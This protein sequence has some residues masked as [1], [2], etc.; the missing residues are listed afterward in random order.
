[1]LKRT[2]HGALHLVGALGAG[3]ALLMLALAWRLSSGPIS[4]TPLTPYAEN[5]LN[6]FH[7]ELRFR[8]GDTV[9]AW[10]GWD[11]TLDMRIQSVRIFEKSGGVIANVPEVS[12]SLSAQALLHGMIAPR[13]IELF[14]PR[15]FL[16]RQADGGFVI[17]LGDIP[18]E[19]QNLLQRLLD[20]LLA[21]TER[22]HPMS[23]LA[24]LNILGADLTIADMARNRSWRLPATQ[25]LI[26]RDAEGL[27]GEATL[28]F[29]TGGG[30]GQVTV[31]SAYRAADGRS[32]ATLTF[33]RARPAAFAEFVEALAPFS[34]LDLPLAGTASIALERNGTVRSFGFNL[35]G[36]EGRLALPDP[37]AQNL[38]LR[39]LA[40]KGHY[41]GIADRLEVERFRLDLGAEGSLIVPGGHAMPLRSAEGRG[42]YARREGRAELTEARFDLGG[43]RVSLAGSGE[44][45][46]ADI[47]V[48]AKGR[49]ENVPADKL[50]LYWPSGWGGDARNWVVPNLSAG[51]MPRAEASLEV[52]IGPDRRPVIVAIDGD[53]DLRDVTVDYLAPMPKAHKVSGRATFNKTRFDI[54]IE[55][56]EAADLAVTGGSIA[57]TGL[58]QYDQYADIELAIAGGFRQ[59]LALIEHEPLRFASALGISPQGAEG[60]VETNLKL[61]FI[62]EHALN[63]NQVDVTANA[64][65]VDIGLRGALLGQDLRQGKLELTLDRKGMDIKGKARVGGMTADIDWRRN[66]DPKATVAS[67]YRLTG[68]S[69]EIRSFADLGFAFGPLG[70]GAVEGTA[71]ADIRVVEG[72]DGTRS[73]EAR[74]D[75]KDLAVE[76]R[77][78]GWRK[79][80]GQPGTAEASLRVKRDTV[81]AIPSFAVAADD[82]TIKGRAVYA[83]DGTGLDR[84]EVD[85]VRYG[86]T[87]ASLVVRQRTD[88]GWDMDVKGASFDFGPLW[89]EVLRGRAA[90]PENETV[91]AL[92]LGITFALDRVW[93]GGDRSLEDVKGAF[94]HDGVRWS[95]AE[96]EGRVGA[97]SAPFI[98]AV[99][100]AADGGKRTLALKAGDAG[101]MLKALDFYDNMVGGTLDIAGEY[102]DRNPGEPLVGRV[103]ARDY[104][105]VNAPLLARLLS[106][107]ALTG[108]LDELKGEGLN[109]AALDLPFVQTEG[110]MELREARA[111]GASLG[112][113]A[114]GKIYTDTDIFDMNGTI[115]PAYAVN[116]LLGNLPVVGT[117]FTGGEK[118][119]GVFAATFRM[120]GPREEP[121]I[122]INPVA[123]LAP[124]FLRNLFG[125]FGTAGRETPPREESR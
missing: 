95:L 30:R 93:M 63:A 106:V 36:G 98:L 13:S 87:D 99:R 6:G 37:A 1:L 104:R 8:L 71:G 19:G 97:K 115:V 108:I 39:S 46:G 119:G 14:G 26:A 2:V 110:V 35:T 85:P 59:G 125:V 29:E 101:A 25:V 112:F 73:I 88:G 80:R 23:Y 41:D 55:K 113:T 72:P 121:N 74:A 33:V 56:G 38:A 91:A 50:D 54:A 84:I 76:V 34:A 69:G 89:S 10:G 64:K 100:P 32:Q 78:L 3:L 67:R 118:G 57:F 27:S 70:D 77:P 79:E 24:R 4:L 40:L 86:R 82:L 120:T 68:R 103:V 43:P 49:L 66:F 94:R 58:D 15:L 12:F 62:L 18:S 90:T 114:A 96:A 122:A 11:R 44:V 109:F 107:A 123:T 28:N 105:I 22:G 124:G 21:P 116:S 65:L 47:V 75:L 16:A 60:K 7:P 20:Q 53:M 42:V 92:K 61:R 102:L 111:F 17:A 83:A 81:A 9:L 45:A 52:R 31:Q 48:R 51:F 117:L 5:A